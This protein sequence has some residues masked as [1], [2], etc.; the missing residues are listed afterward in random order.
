MTAIA[1]HLSD[2]LQAALAQLRAA[3][4]SREDV[5]PEYPFVAS[6]VAQLHRVTAGPDTASLDEQT[7]RDLLLDRYSDQLAC[8]V[9]IFGRQVLHQRLRAG[10]D[11]AAAGALGERLRA[12]MEDP[13]R[14]EEL[15]RELRS[16]RHAETEVVTLLFEDEAPVPPAWAG[17]TWPL[18][19]GLMASI[20]AVAWSPLAWLGT[21]LALYLLISIQ[22]RYHERVEAWARAAN[23]LQMLLRVCSLLGARD[24]PLLHAF[25]GGR[26]LAGQINRSLSR[27]M[28]S[29]VVPG[30]DVYADW[31]RLANVNHYFKSVAIVFAQR[32]F[33]REC[34]TRCANLEAD[35]ALARHLLR[36]QTWCWAGRQADAGIVLAGA[37]HPLLERAAPLSIALHGKG[38]FISGQNGIG[39][40]TFLRMAG[41]NLVAA[42]AFGFCYAQRAQ[43]PPLPV[44]ASLQNEDSLA[45]GES[46]YLSELRRARELLAAA[47]GPRPGICLVD[48]VFRGTNHVESVSAAA[49]VLDV[50][51]AH[52]PLLASSHHLV[53]APLLAHRLDP[54]CIGP[55]DRAPGGLA[56]A[57]G[58]LAHTNGVA[59][60]AEQGFDRQVQDSAARIACWLGERLAQPVDCGTVLAGAGGTRVC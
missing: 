12:L 28:F 10:L 50:L 14:L 22:L 29:R 38:A 3:F 51:A 53:L 52:G 2:L 21:G 19:L 23:A 26:E 48:E 39:K 45:D 1:H 15:H 9:S 6:D 58:V 40:S 47:Q 4:A 24:H 36:T 25:G 44:Y 16:L 27:S 8:E 41:L 18:P 5:L 43:L 7:W 31:F 34:Y 11:D 32:A 33:L 13:A 57:P 49:A 30:A 59:L 17:R 60:L 35:V 37:V 56:L 54:Y 20:A 55:D 42:R 46:L